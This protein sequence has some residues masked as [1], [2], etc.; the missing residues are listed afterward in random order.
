M[1]G[2]GTDGG[3][4][5]C[6]DRKVDAIRND[7]DA[8]DGFGATQPREDTLSRGST[9]RTWS[10]GWIVASGSSEALEQVWA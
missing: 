6:H 7:D 3:E 5:G 4:Y 10:N 2:G 1:V 8:R 9:G